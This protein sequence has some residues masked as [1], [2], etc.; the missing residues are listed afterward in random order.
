MSSKLRKFEEMDILAGSEALAASYTAA[1]S[2]INIEGLSKITFYGIASNH[3]GGAAFEVF[4][5]ESSTTTPT[6]LTGF[7]GLST[8]A[9]GELIEFAIGQN[10]R[11]AFSIPVSGQYLGIKAKY[12][13][14]GGTSNRLTLKAIGA[15]VSTI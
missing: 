1:G 13:G 8:A 5:I 2:I 15:G 11:R 4:V 3:T 12:G 9:D 14:G 7:K 6:D 10:V